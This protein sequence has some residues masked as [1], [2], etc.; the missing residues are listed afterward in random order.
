MKNPT[1]ALIVAMQRKREAAGMSIRKL[2]DVI[3]VSF[4][5]LSRLERFESEPDTN[6]RVRIINW[7]QKDAEDIGIAFE[8]VASVHFR[9]SKQIDSKTT[10]CLVRAASLIKEKFTSK[11]F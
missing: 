11:D 4:S 10:E 8:N 2:A 3:G 6:T 7:L 1:K 9:A 5:T